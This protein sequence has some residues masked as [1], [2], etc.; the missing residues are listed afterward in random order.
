MMN[1]TTAA[2]IMMSDTASIPSVR[3]ACSS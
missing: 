2:A 1:T 3:P